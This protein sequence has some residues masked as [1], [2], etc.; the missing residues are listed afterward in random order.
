MSSDTP[1]YYPEG[2]DRERLL[3]SVTNDLDSLTEDQWAVFRE[4]LRADK[5]EQGFEE[6]FDEMWRREKIAKGIKDTVSEPP[7]MEIMRLR[8]ERI[9]SSAKWDPWGFV[10]FKSPEIQDQAKWQACR[11]RFDII[12]QDYIDQY[13]ECPGVDEYLSKMEFRWIEDAG[14]AEGSIKSIAEARTALELPPGLDHSL[15]LYITPASLDSILNSPLPS[16]AKRKWRKNIPFVL[17]VS[18]KAAKEP[19]A[20]DIEDDVAGADWRGY[21]N[22]AVESLLDSFFSTVAGDLR[23]PFQLGGHV[24]GEDIYCDH[25]RGGIHKAGIGYW[26]GRAR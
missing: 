21:F 13:R 4:G 2:W 3:N 9:G 15:S 6:F 22:V 18:M 24:S 10:G 25:T 23:S 5:G 20:Q 19:N 12:L 26:D 7:F 16:S 14:D 8:E 11:E 1:A 17:A